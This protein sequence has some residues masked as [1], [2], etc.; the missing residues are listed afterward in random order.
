MKLLRLLCAVLTLGVLGG[1]NSTTQSTP[2]PSSTS[3]PAVIFPQD[4]LGRDIKL[5]APAQRVVCIGPG[6]TEAIFALGAGDKLIGRDQISDYPKA[7][8]KVP[9]VGDYVGPS[10]EK[11]IALRPD[12]VIVQG[13]TYDKA[14]VENWQ[15]KIGAPVAVLVPTTVEKVG[16]GIEKIAAWL[17][18]TEKLPAVTATFHVQPMALQKQSAF[19]EVQRSPLWTSGN[20]TLIADEIRSLGLQNVAADISGYKAFNTEVLLKRDPDFY[21]VTM[22]EPDRDK[23]L[24]ELRKNPALGNLT[25]VRKGRVLVVD[26]DLVLRPGPRLPLGIQSLAKEISRLNNS[27]SN[28]QKN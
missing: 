17:N 20:G 21:I 19:Y 5:K 9:V 8:L 2:P 25:A 22:E 7:A 15:Q 12:L 1:C 10:V 3:A 28:H 24:R 11:V 6:A 13:E 23:A 14:R 16:A 18:A 26:S 27:T 4:D